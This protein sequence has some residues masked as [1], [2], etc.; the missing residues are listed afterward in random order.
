MPRSLLIAITAGLLLAA[1]QIAQA[2]CVGTT[3]LG[4]HP[5]GLT[6]D[7]GVIQGAINT[8]SNNGGGVVVLPS[9]RYLVTGTLT[10]RRRVVLCGGTDGPFDVG[11]VNPAVTTTA[12]TLLITNTTAPFITLEDVG[13]AVTDLLFHYPNQVFH[14]PNQPPTANEPL[15]YPFTIYVPVG[16]TRIERCTVTNAYD[17]LDIERGRVT[18][19]DLYI[20]AFHI[21]ILVDHALDHVTLSDII[22]SVFWDA[23][24]WPQA[25]DSWVL[26][27]GYAFVL[28]RV[29]GISIHNVLVFNRY[30]AFLL[31]D[32]WDTAQLRTMGYG[33]ATNIDIDTCR[34]GISA[35]STASPGYK[36]SNIDIGCGTP[37]NPAYW[38][39]AQLPPGPTSAAPRV[40]VNGGSIRGTWAG[41]LFQTF[42]GGGDLV[43]VHVF[44]Y[45]EGL[46]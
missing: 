20:G 25:I 21:G 27:N 29:D 9:G 12:A 3:P 37:S 46:N 2:T 42:T 4:L 39:V 26:S 7:T 13:A 10:V 40:A 18:A 30:I 36:F 28:Q 14:Y 23:Y 33:S 16:G 43:A 34:Y 32:S 38:G 22:H 6:D 1:P 24:T 35:R 17:F 45:D 19:R 8:A 5:N 11:P 41:G 31:E 44:G 15:V